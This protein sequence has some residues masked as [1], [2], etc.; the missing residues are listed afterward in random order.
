VMLCGSRSLR[1]S[2][3]KRDGRSLRG[4]VDEKK[5]ENETISDNKLNRKIKRVDREEDDKATEDE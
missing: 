5:N 1:R 3:K 4:K 2:K